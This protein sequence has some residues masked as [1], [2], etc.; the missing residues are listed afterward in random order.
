MSV[1]FAVFKR[2]EKNGYITRWR[3]T[4]LYLFHPDVSFNDAQEAY[5]QLHPDDILMAR[6]TYKHI[7]GG[8]VGEGWDREHIL[9][10][11]K[12]RITYEP[13]LHY[14]PNGEA[15]AQEAIKNIKKRIEG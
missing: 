6:G 13:C 1:G 5:R 12:W 14:S 7:M 9:E 4:V 10:H 2:I 3:K 15:V 8:F 11:D